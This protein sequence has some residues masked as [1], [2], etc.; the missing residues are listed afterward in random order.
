MTKVEQ[1]MKL[2]KGC[3]QTYRTVICHVTGLRQ[4]NSFDD[5]EKHFQSLDENELQCAIED[6]IDETVES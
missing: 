5:V 3:D 6:M 4:A 2:F 1:A